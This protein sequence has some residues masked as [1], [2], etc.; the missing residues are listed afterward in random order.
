MFDPHRVLEYVFDE[1]QLQLGHGVLEEFWHQARANGV[2]WAALGHDGGELRVPVKLFGDDCKVGKAC[3]EKVS[4]IFL[5]CPLFRPYAARQSRW[6]LWSMRHTLFL[7]P[8]TLRPILAR[9]TWSLNLAYDQALPKSGLKFVCTEISGDWKWQYDMWEYLPHWNSK[10]ICPFCPVLKTDYAACDPPE[11]RGT[12]EF[13]AEVLPRV[14]AALVLLRGFDVSVVQ[15]CQLHV[16]NL[17]LL[18][19]A[20]GSSLLYLCVKGYFGD[21]V[22]SSLPTLLERAYADFLLWASAT[23]ARHNQKRFT[24]KYVI[25][26]ESGAYMCSKGHNSRVLVEWLRD[27]S[28]HAFGGNLDVPYRIFGNWLHSQNKRPAPDH[29]LVPQTMALPL[30]CIDGVMVHVCSVHGLS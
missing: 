24:V 25:K 6:L 7:G 17:G 3:G 18:W 10:A 9:I 22:G 16:L 23:K 4:S 12:N 27:C 11:W 20:N 13:V 21:P 1:C 2:P 29:F 26:K 19:T 14:P 8:I 30:T 15:I 5:S 28:M